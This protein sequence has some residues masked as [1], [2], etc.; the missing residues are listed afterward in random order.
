MVVQAYNRMG[1]GPRSEPVNV[2]TG[3]DGTDEIPQTKKKKI[4][5]ILLVTFLVPSSPPGNVHCTALSST[6]LLVMWSPPPARDINGKLK[7]YTVFFRQL[8]EW[9]GEDSFL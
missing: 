4:T 1:A 5:S 7:E 9:E 8:R 6:S 2:R 3:E